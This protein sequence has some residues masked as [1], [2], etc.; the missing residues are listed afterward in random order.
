MKA[1]SKSIKVHIDGKIIKKKNAT[2]TFIAVINYLGPEKVA[3][4]VSIRADGLPLVVP[5]KDYRLQLKELDSNYF[6]STHMP[7]TYKKRM[8]ERIG[9]ALNVKIVVDI[10]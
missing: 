9:E 4:L 6:V 7:T 8:L 2:E 1:P 5:K 10:K 3:Q